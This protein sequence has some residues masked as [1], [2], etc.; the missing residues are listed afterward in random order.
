MKTAAFIS[1]LLLAIAAS[2]ALAEEKFSTLTGIP[3]EAMSYGD[4]DKVEGKFLNY[5]PQFGAWVFTND[6][7]GAT[8]ANYGSGWKFTGY[9]PLTRG[10]PILDG[11]LRS[12]STF[13]EGLLGGS[14]LANQVRQTPSLYGS[15]GW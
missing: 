7:T 2:G 8:Y 5:F 9:I 10:T 13:L 6:I 4:M 3:A 11:L 1:G 14:D 15:K 12:R